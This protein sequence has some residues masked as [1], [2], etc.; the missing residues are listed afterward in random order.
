M[1]MIYGS[2]SGEARLL[3]FRVEERERQ[4]EGSEHRRDVAPAVGDLAARG[5]LTS[6]FEIVVGPPRTVRV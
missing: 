4:I 1:F 3:T 6:G 5:L 2:G